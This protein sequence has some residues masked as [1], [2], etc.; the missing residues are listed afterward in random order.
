MN[1]I[2]H[3]AAI[4]FAVIFGFSFMFSKVA[5][6]YVTPIGLISYRF[7]VAF[8]VFELLR[9]CKVIHIRFQFRYIRSLLLVAIFQP[10]LY[11]L[12]EVYGLART[13]SSEAGMMI[14]LIPIFVS[15]LSTFILKEK[16]KLVQVLFILM[17]VFGIIY[18]QLMKSGS[19]IDFE[20]VGFVLL[21]GAV[22]S[23][24]V[25]NITSRNASKVLKP[26]E[27]TYF[28]ML[29]G[30][31]VFNIIYLI[32]LIG[33]NR[34]EDYVLNLRHLEL[35]LPI[36][37]LGV[38]A[39]IGGFFLVNYALS[40]LE[41]HVASI[42]SNLAT[43]VSIIAGAVFLGETLFYYHYLGSVLI[44]VGVYGTVRSNHRKRLKEEFD[45]T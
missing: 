9:L 4:S 25:F 39:S 37:Y 17:S 36:L 22:I 6:D 34:V 26:Y 27:L 10:V 18:I 28:M 7:L 44:I 23:A 30:A 29:I 42:Y 1:R 8:I 33:E 16:P 20:L 43:I 14:A 5:M 41:A 38:I 15:L 40:H 21:F 12:F 11:F 45:G 24:A 13:S 32:D 2:V 3:L 31:V 35:I 19:G